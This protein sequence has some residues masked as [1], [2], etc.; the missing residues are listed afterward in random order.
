MYN[1]N[2]I[3]ADEAELSLLVFMLTDGCH[4]PTLPLKPSGG[5][6]LWCGIYAADEIGLW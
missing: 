2:H 3:N 5:R 1:V 6:V 4:T